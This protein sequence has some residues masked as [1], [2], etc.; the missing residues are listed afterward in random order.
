MQNMTGPFIQ[1]QKSKMMHWVS[2][3]LNRCQPYSLF[4]SLQQ[5][6]CFSALLFLGLFSA[7]GDKDRS[8]Q[9]LNLMNFH[10]ALLI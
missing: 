6:K 3:I 2:L 4:P 10:I 1:N 7:R 9:L 8:G 5:L